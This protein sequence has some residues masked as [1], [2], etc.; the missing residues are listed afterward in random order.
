[1]R[2]PLALFV[3][4]GLLFVFGIGFVVVAARSAKTV[5][6]VA[7]TVSLKMMPIAS[8]RQLMGGIIA[9]G[10]TVVFESV[11]TTVTENGV[12]EKA[13][14]TDEDWAMVGNA[15]AAL[16]E[17]GNLLMVDGRAVDRGEWMKMSQAMIDASKLVLKAVDAQ[18]T[19][20]ILAA[21]EPL[22]ESCDSCH[23]RYQRQ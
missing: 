2:N 12:D 18:D 5:P 13:P 16:A 22:N 21:G 9:P 19:E 3:V 4:S 17:A 7:E 23:Q 20:G 11:S 14:R 6:V 10:A 8:T 15:A 1:M